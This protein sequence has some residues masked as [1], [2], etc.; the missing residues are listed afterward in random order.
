MIILIT[1]KKKI[2]DVYH[3]KFGLV[4]TSKSFSLP[5]YI[6]HINTI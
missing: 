1:L 5:T 2:A 6:L 3:N 4:D